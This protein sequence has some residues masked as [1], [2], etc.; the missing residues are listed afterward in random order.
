MQSENDIND[1]LDHLVGMIRKSMKFWDEIHSAPN[2][3]N[4]IVPVP[5]AQGWVSLFQAEIDS[6]INN[7]EPS[8][9][10]KNA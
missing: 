1:R 3:P 2:E 8:R 7:T 5:P 10:L 4:P 6:K 9:G